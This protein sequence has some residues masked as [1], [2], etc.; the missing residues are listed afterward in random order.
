EHIAAHA[1]RTPDK[2]AIIFAD[3]VWSHAKLDRSANRLAHRLIKLGIG[4]DISVAI[5]VKRSPEAIVGILATLKAGGAYIPVEPDHP[6]S[7]NHHILR[8]GGVKVIL[9]HSWLLDRIPEGLDAVILEL[10]KLDL[11]EEPD[12]V[13]DVKVHKDQLA[14]IMYTSGSTGLP[15]GVA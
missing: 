9:T 14:Y 15:K 11:S 4:A 13:P 7:R 6:T 2:T 3:E 5:A 10:D 12:S 1:Q 8:D